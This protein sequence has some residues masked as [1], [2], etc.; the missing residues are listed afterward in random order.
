M[1]ADGSG[2][3]N[4]TNHPAN[5]LSPTWSPDG[6][7]LA[8]ISDRNGDYQVYVMSADG[9]Q[10]RQLTD[11]ATGAGKPVWSPDGG[12]IAFSTSS[13]RL[14]RLDIYWINSD[15]SDL[16]HV[17]NDN[18]YGGRITWSPDGGQLLF[19]SRVSG[20]FNLYMINLD[21]S[22]LRILADSEITWGPSAGRASWEFNPT[23]SP[24][25]QFI[26]FGTDRAG[27]AVDIYVVDQHGNQPL[28]LTEPTGANSGPVWSPDSRWV[29][30][31]S[32]EGLHIT[33]PNS[34]QTVKLND[35]SLGGPD[36]DKSWSPDSG[37]VIFSTRE[38][39]QFEVYSVTAD[40]RGE[41]NLTK[42]PA[43][44]TQPTWR[45]GP[46]PLPAEGWIAYLDHQGNVQL[47][48]S[49]GADHR[50]VTSD[51]H[52][53]GNIADIGLKW[54]PNGQH[55]AFVRQD[56]AGALGQESLL[57]YDPIADFLQVLVMGDDINGFDWSP[58]SR[59]L[60]YGREIPE[61][62]WAN[63][64]DPG[65]PIP[66]LWQVELISG[67]RSELVPSPGAPIIRPQWSPDGRY[68]SF[69]EVAG[70]EGSGYFTVYDLVAKSFVNVG[71]EAQLGAYSWS[72]DGSGVAFDGI[73]YDGRGEGLWHV[74]I[75]ALHALK[76]TLAPPNGTDEFPLFSTSGEYIAFLRAAGDP[77]ENSPVQIW[78]M[79]GESAEPRL[80]TALPLTDFFD[81]FSWASDDQ[82]LVVSSGS[83]AQSQIYIVELESGAARFLT[84]GR[85]PEWQ[86]SGEVMVGDAQPWLDEKAGLIHQL[87]SV[88]ILTELFTVPAVTAYDET[89]ARDLYDRLN[90]EFEQGTLSPEQLEAFV[91]L[92]LQER[93]LSQLLPEY[94]TV[95]ATIADSSAGTIET[96]LGVIFILRPAWNSCRDAIPFCGRIQAAT[97]R[98]V[99]RLVNDTG[100]LAS[101][102]LGPGPEEQETGARFW[103]LLVR[104]AQD[105]FSQGGSL[106][107]LLVDTGIQAAGT[108]VIVES[109]Y[110]KPT[111]ELLDKGIATADLERPSGDVWPITGDSER[112]S[113]QMAQYSD[114]A[115]YERE[116][117]LE[118]H[119]EFQRAANI[120]EVAEDL[121][122]LAMLSPFA[123]IA[124]AVG[125]GARL[126][127][128]FLVD[129]PLAYLNYQSLECVGYLGRRAAEVAFDAEPPFES[130]RERI[131][132][133]LPKKEPAAAAYRYPPTAFLAPPNLTT[134]AEQ[135]REAVQT[136]MVAVEAKE[137]LAVEAA[138]EE[139]S[140]AEASFEGALD[141]TLA[142]LLTQEVVTEE[143]LNLVGQSLAFTTNNFA[144]YLALAE[145][146]MA[147][148][149][150]SEPQ[151]DLTR[152]AQS[153]VQTADDIEA[154][155]E[156]VNVSP[157]TNKAIVVIQQIEAERIPDA[158]LQ[159][160]VG[161][162]NVGTAEA[163]GIEVALVTGEE[164]M[165]ETVTIDSLPAGEETTVTLMAPVPATG[166]FAVQVRAQ[167]VL[168]NTHLGGVPEIV[169]QLPPATSIAEQSE[170]EGEASAGQ[171]EGA[172]V[173]ED[174]AA[175]EEGMETPQED[176]AV[177]SEIIREDQVT[178]LPLIVTGALGGLLVAVIGI[179]ILWRR[180][181]R[182]AHPEAIANRFCIHCG[183][184][185]P[186]FG[187]YCIKCGREKG[188][189][190]A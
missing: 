94:T 133:A 49:D 75:P 21:G 62:F 32:V 109:L 28:N 168:M 20:D 145:T 186:S 108:Y 2:L 92:T 19:D 78:V 147:Q 185:Y 82:H 12:R 57:V 7:Q 54:S 76:L 27:G 105:H 4:L 10:V 37:H 153:A 110:L 136:L 187:R 114:V 119:Q 61:E 40:G 79:G 31:L 26:A 111:Q 125:L 17:Y 58:E 178:S 56:F 165:G 98:T 29:V 77:Q 137:M 175:P 30:Y 163:A 155:M 138:L 93:A 112:A 102:L 103:N 126:E 141:G 188:D 89:A 50:L 63:P 53:S 173:T 90:T 69:E 150:G 46:P 124:R 39:E 41:T 182:M 33:D 51:G 18:S 118:R 80:V 60:V 113:L 179:M 157:P 1:N 146:L 100:Q 101:R 166:F 181:R 44:D 81:S 177:M 9:S 85:S 106:Q 170:L 71:S 14:D 143:D 35:L 38:G 47:I 156:R 59:R 8:F 13:N 148:E 52:E 130:C 176:A 115:G 121:A 64:V 120:A 16:T 15:G 66:G 161:L 129:L 169:T 84:S 6:T 171:A 70:M 48:S 174:V 116:D 22:N 24:D 140:R 189:S 162:S 74:N 127:Q 154:S 135:Y 55:L 36:V 73:T 88:D 144:L 180:Q 97:E 164:Q 122:D 5:D 42:H 87:E 159:L 107:E 117:A 83:F 123:L 65:V 142:T 86:P 149:A 132:A 91:R 95:A 25:G 167:G 43:N 45:P 68:L 128:L 23:W 160:E 72:P 34:G 152:V 104:L 3:V 151:S 131:G 11:L 184:E 172:E 190:G 134:E 139:M 158:Q 96:A 67:Q 183:A 99:W